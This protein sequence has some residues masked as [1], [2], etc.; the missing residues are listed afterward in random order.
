MTAKRLDLCAAQFAL[1]LHHLRTNPVRDR[2]CVEI[3]SGW[4]LSHA[5]IC[6]LLGARKV[7]ATDIRPMAYPAFLRQALHNAEQ[8]IIRDVLAPYCPHTD[9]RRRLENLLSL[10]EFSFESLK[11]LGIEYVSPLDLGR[12][13][14]SFKADFIFSFAV[15]EHVPAVHVAPLLKNLADSLNPG[16]SMVH[17]IHLEDHRDFNDP[18]VFLSASEGDYTDKVQTIR[19]NRIRR[20]QWRRF[21]GE[22]PGIES[23]FIYEWSR[24]DR[25]LPEKISPEVLYENE[26][27]LRVTHLGVYSEKK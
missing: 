19:G 14:L 24:I 18:F 3:G 9:I 7:Y 6:H 2:V 23:R 21:F 1:V 10:R 11:G 5:M 8:S 4:V 25:K 12:Q 17:C 20:S 15:M 27:D 22:I 26:Q 13:P 16:G